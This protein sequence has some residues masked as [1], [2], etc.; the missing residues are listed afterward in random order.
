MG[1]DPV[2]SL[3]IRF[4]TMSLCRFS[5]KAAFPITRSD[6]FNEDYKVD[7]FFET[8][9]SQQLFPLASIEIVFS[10]F[11]H[12]FSLSVLLTRPQ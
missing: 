5:F 2:A 11:T 12:L 7:N 3:L 4:I 6:A 8:S 10:P 9:S 1:L